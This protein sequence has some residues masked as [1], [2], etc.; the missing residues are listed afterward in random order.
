[1]EVA[2]SGL[3]LPGHGSVPRAV[4]WAGMGRPFRAGVAARGFDLMVSKAKDLLS[5]PTEVGATT[6][7]SSAGGIV[8]S[9]Q[10]SPDI[11]FWDFLEPIVLSGFP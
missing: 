5:I 1:M 6:S 3:A 8:D 4:P 7:T 9:W 2:P 11:F 10:R